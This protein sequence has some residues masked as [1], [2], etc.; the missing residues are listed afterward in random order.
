MW[1]PY[2]L[3]ENFVPFKFINEKLR[4]GYLTDGVKITRASFNIAMLRTQNAKQLQLNL[5]MWQE[6]VRCLAGIWIKYP[7]DIG[8]TVKPQLINIIWLWY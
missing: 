7:G 3:V 6:R 2:G 4:Y 1:L 8:L 5:S